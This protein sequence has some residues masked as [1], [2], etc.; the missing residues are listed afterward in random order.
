MR[1]TVAM[2]EILKYKL[3]SAF[4]NISEFD[5]IA[6]P[7]EFIEIILWNNGE[8]FDV[9]LSAKE[10]QRFSLTWCEFKAIKKLIKEL[11]E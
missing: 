9:H 2:T 6:E 3:D 1:Q 7:D 11:D 5:P 10:T 4:A 8:G